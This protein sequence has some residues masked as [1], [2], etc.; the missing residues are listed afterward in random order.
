ML[1][2]KTHVWGWGDECAWC[3]GRDEQ[4]EEAV[5]WADLGYASRT[6]QEPSK[7]A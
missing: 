1:W 7:C 6:K 4:Q 5:T 2:T 3:Y